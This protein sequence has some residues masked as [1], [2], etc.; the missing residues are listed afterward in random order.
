M[1]GSEPVC[2]NKKFIGQIACPIIFLCLCWVFCENLPLSRT[3]LFCIWK[4]CKFFWVYA[5]ALH[6]GYAKKSLLLIN[7]SFFNEA[8]PNIQSI[9]YHLWKYFIE[10]HVEIINTMLINL[11]SLTPKVLQWNLILYNAGCWAQ[12]DQVIFAPPLSPSSTN[13]PKKT[14]FL[15]N[16]LF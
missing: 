6:L 1:G 14:S 9:I 4:S 7:V 11:Y 2:Q 13:M 8:F 10:H 16:K 12:A 5:S 3:N 15:W